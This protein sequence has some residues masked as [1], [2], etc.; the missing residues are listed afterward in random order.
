MDNAAAH[1][2]LPFFL[3][4]IL[5]LHPALQ[6]LIWCVLVAFMQRLPLAPLSGVAAVLLLAGALLAGKKLWQLLRRTRWIFLS[7]LI[8][9]AY[10]TPGDA[11]W[12]SLGVCSPVREG[13]QDGAT[14]LLRL[15]AALAS[16]AILLHKLHRLELISG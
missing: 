1:H 3:E 8:I 11:L 12:Q 2:G 13:L 5:S 16:L 15:L 9:Y 10:T 14:Q 7:L 6:I 4:R